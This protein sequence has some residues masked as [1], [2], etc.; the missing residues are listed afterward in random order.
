M[1]IWNVY[2]EK[3]LDATKIA[4][5]QRTKGSGIRR[6]NSV[7][8]AAARLPNSLSV[9]KLSVRTRL[10]SALYGR[11]LLANICKRS[12]VRAA[13]DLFAHFTPLSLSFPG[14]AERL[15]LCFREFLIGIGERERE[16]ERGGGEREIKR[17][18]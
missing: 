15:A 7:T 4:A 16:R 5:Q 8:P 14:R 13:L 6:G 10:S 3:T 17:D 11:F 1:G 2:I 9:R 12:K 18:E